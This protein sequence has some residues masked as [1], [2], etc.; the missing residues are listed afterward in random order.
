[1]PIPPND[2]LIGPYQV[3]KLIRTGL[4]LGFREMFRNDTAYKYADLQDKRTD[5]DNTIIEITDVDPIECVKF[6]ALIV[7]ALT[8]RG[9]TFFFSDDLFFEKRDKDGRV[10][11]EVRGNAVRLTLTVEAWGFSSV[12]RDE[13]TDKAYIYSRTIRDRLALLGIEIRQVELLSPR[14]EV[15]GTRMHF[16]S[17]VSINTYSEWEI[18]D[19]LEPSDVIQ[20]FAIGLQS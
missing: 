12:E 6:P 14:Q 15:L 2:P 4:V 13:L 8:D 5:I 17:G 18:S 1:M 16:V 7:T 20:K 10:L 11:E 3:S 9:S 19:V